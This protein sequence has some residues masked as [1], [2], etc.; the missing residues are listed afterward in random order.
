[1]SHSGLMSHPTARHGSRRRL[2]RAFALWALAA[3]AAAGILLALLGALVGVGDHTTLI[4]ASI[5]LLIAA[6][7]VVAALLRPPN[8][9]LGV[10]YLAI[11][12]I[13]VI[14]AFLATREI[15]TI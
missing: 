7:M 4:L 3:P 2:V 6:G 10:A 5:A 1:M 11:W 13:I 15:L 14:I 12:S 9:R 8:F